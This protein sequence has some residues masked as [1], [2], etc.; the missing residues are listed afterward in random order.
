LRIGERRVGELGYLFARCAARAWCSAERLPV[1]DSGRVVAVCLFD[2][3]HASVTCRRR[4]G[5]GAPLSSAAHRIRNFPTLL[6]FRGGSEVARRSG[7]VPLGTLLD[8][9]R[10]H[11]R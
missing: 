11:A 10:Q 6:V 9:I 3:A 4:D 1:A 8:W 2:A 5:D 7:A